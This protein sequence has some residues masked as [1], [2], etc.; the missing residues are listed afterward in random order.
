LKTQ[1]NKHGKDFE[2]VIAQSW[3]DCGYNLER[4][5]I[6]DDGQEAVADEVVISD[7]FTLYNELKS[8][9]A[10]SF[11]LSG[12][13]IHQI[14]SLAKLSTK[15]KNIRSLVVIEFVKHE[16]VAVFSIRE[17]VNIIKSGTSSVKYG[18]IRD[19]NCLILKK[20]NNK[21]PVSSIISEIKKGGLK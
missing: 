21:Y 14:R 13:K 7:D 17:I 12:L 15:R 3:A 18:K 8:T 1:P 20:K 19:L 6:S 5:N 11:K 9:K 10:E 16:T 4:M 2:K